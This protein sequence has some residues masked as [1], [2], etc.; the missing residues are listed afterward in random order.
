VLLGWLAVRGGPAHGPQG[1]GLP[2]V[3]SKHND[4]S[5]AAAT[6]DVSGERLKLGR[7][8]RKSQRKMFN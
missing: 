5:A 4:T 2:Q 1:R 8:D 3:T 6:G 7:R